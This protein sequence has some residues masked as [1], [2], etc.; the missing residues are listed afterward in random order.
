MLSVRTPL[1]TLP[2]PR[3]SQLS[4]LR[5]LSLADKEN[6]P[7]SLSGT[8]VLASKTARRIF[9]EPTEPQQ[10]SKSLVPSAE[11]EP[12]LRENPRRF[13]VFPIEALKAEERY[14]ISHVLAFF[15]ASDGIVNENLV[16]RFSQEVQITEARCFYGFQIAM[17]NIH[18]EMYSLLIDTYIKDSKEREFLFN[19]IET[20]PCVK[21]K[22]D[23]ALRW[24]GDKEATYGERV[25]AFAAV[26]GIF[27]SGSFASIFWL[28]K[29]G[30]MPGLTFSNELI[31]RDE[32]LHCDFACLMFKHLV[33]KPSEQRVKEIVINAGNI[34]VRAEHG[35]TGVRDTRALLSEI[36]LKSRLQPA[37]PTYT[38]G[39]YR[40]P[41]G[42]S[43]FLGALF[44]GRLFPA[45]HRSPILFPVPTSTLPHE[46][47]IFLSTASAFPRSKWSAVFSML[48]RGVTAMASA[49]G[50]AR[51][52][53]APAS[54]PC[55]SWQAETASGPALGTTCTL[56]S[57]PYLAAAQ[58]LARL[59]VGADGGAGGPL[60]PLKLAEGMKDVH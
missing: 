19:A 26:E 29:R 20:M 25:V 51:V 48:A 3:Q 28:K 58:D 37:Q 46:A 13:V 21:K 7:P 8:R 40:S 24:I 14:F 50:S 9:Q 11:E 31:S 10:R 54:Q 36:G 55:R 4:P 42:L 12:L 45:A 35:G 39:P 47:S 34:I 16:E 5:G 18:S 30:L 22:A 43:P 56:S 1:V 2:S 32:G 44:L 60:R 17:E 15:A 53:Q 41:Y 23:W 52:I 38:W 57:Q 27:F 49:P 6:T 33:H 59:A